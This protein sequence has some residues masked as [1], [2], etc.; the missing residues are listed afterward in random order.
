MPFCLLMC[1]IIISPG[2]NGGTK[3][4][5]ANSGTSLIPIKYVNDFEERA[6]LNILSHEYIHTGS[7]DLN[8]RYTAWLS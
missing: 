8:K 7:A 1:L 3:G 6:D 2:F 5:F 4:I